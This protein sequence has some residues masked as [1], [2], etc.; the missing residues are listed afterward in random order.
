MVACFDSLDSRNLYLTHLVD[1]PMTN[2]AARSRRLVVDLMYSCLN[3]V[4]VNFG[5]SI[6]LNAWRLVLN[7]KSII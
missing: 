1:Y 5:H 7:F 4:H 3:D 2:S 6:L